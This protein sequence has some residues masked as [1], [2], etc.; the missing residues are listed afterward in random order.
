[1]TIRPEDWAEL[2]DI[3]AHD[4]K[5]PITAVKGY[6]E[7]IEQAGA[8]NERQQMFAERAFS[9]L[10]RMEQL[11]TML[12]DVTWIDTEKPL[13]WRTCDLRAM[14]DE[15]VLL[16]ESLATPRGISITVDAEPSLGT[17]LGDARRLSQVF[18]NLLSNA[19]KYNHDNGL[20]EISAGGDSEWAYIRVRDTGIGIAPDEH[21]QVFDRFF[22]ARTGRLIEGT[23]LG[24]AIVKEVVERHGGSV[25]LESA[26]DV[27]STF[28]VILP[29]RPDVIEGAHNTD[30][31]APHLP[32]DHTESRD[33][34]RETTASEIGDA[35][36]DDLQE[37]ENMDAQQGNE[38]I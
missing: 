15:S 30:D 29:R 3:V 20:I 34:H 18:N 26:P 19:I 7:L 5:T 4:L 8:L 38:H 6:I 17:I 2:L 16:V 10:R 11:V 28:T 24:L 22:R 33:H 25:R 9:G 23:G 12:L 31:A 21:A 27:G 32:H 35:V 1:M 37:S 13:D 14:I 36:E